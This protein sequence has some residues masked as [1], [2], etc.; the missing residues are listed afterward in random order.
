MESIYWLLC[1]VVAYLF[2]SL[3]FAII[4]TRS[5]R[6]E[7]IRTLG[8]KNPGTANVGR[9]L[10]TGW[11][12]LV[13]L[14]DI[15]KSVLPIL[16]ARTLVFN[17]GDPLE[18]IVT[19]TVGIAA[20]IGHCRPLYHGFRGGGGIATSIGVYVML[21]PVEALVALFAAAGIVALV[22]RNVEHKFGP[23]TPVLFVTLVPALTTVTALW[24]DIPLVRG[25]KVGAYRWYEV[26]GI[27][28]LSLSILALNPTFLH[29]RLGDLKSGRDPAH[30][31][32]DA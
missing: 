21:V 20:V 4:I 12:A 19:L 25:I 22:V 27:F 5:V 28:V 6:G 15:S 3:N 8:N 9:S 11:G 16:L 24:L 31:D 7:D 30:S 26:A 1:V 23:Y 29:R 10:G 2:G 14:L 17:P 18:P 13:L 32:E